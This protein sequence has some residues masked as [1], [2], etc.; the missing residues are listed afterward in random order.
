MN[1]E[2]IK[3]AIVGDCSDWN[4]KDITKEN[5]PLEIRDKIKACDIFIFNLEGPII[6]DR[7]VAEGAIKNSFLKKVLDSRGKLQPVVTNTE[8]LLDVLNL[9]K[10][11]VACLANNHI[12]DAGGLGIDFTLKSLEKKGFL[13]LGTGRNINEASK[14]LMI[15]V[16]GKKIGIV[17]YN[18]IGWRKFGFFVV[19]LFGATQKRA[20]ANHASKQRIIEDV[21]SLSEQVDYTIAIMHIGKELH[22]TLSLEDQQFLES[23]KADL[24]VV[25]HAHIIQSIDSKKIISC[26]DFIFNYPDHLPEGREAKT[27]ICSLNKKESIVTDI[28]IIREGICYV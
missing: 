7:I 1:S 18:F 20:G 6:N 10:I 27:I 16:R 11:N 19:N 28:I 9:A 15:E 24:I 4:Q 17:N 26:G 23:I 2:G 12:L 13:F 5:I 8:N 3:I 21:K 25:H 22:E 14:P